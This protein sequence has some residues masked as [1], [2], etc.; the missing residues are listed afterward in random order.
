MNEAQRSEIRKRPPRA[1]YGKEKVIRNYDLDHAE[2]LIIMPKL[3]YRLVEI[4]DQP[5]TIDMSNFIDA[6]IIEKGTHTVDWSILITT[7]DQLIKINKYASQAAKQ[8]D[9]Q[10]NDRL[11][12]VF[13][14]NSLV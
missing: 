13:F 9:M 6:W 4:P 10:N 8:F 1:F 5:L 12:D 3:K 14:G 11:A 7:S 2:L